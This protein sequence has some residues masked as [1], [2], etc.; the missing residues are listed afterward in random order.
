LKSPGRT[1]PS[2]IRWIVDRERYLA[3]NLKIE[4]EIATLYQGQTLPRVQPDS[5]AGPL[6][7]CAAMLAMDEIKIQL[8]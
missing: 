1:L 7:P 4:A 5:L 6:K 2:G 8:R 3:A